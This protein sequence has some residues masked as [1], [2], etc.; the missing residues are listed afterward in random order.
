[1]RDYSLYLKD[2]LAAMESIE[3]FIAGMDLDTFQKDDKTTSAV[4]RKLV[5]LWHRLPSGLE[6]GYRTTTTG[7]ARDSEGIAK[8][9]LTQRGVDSRDPPR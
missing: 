2:I 3:C 7:Q 4:M 1:M 9:R 6:N 5:L 8:C